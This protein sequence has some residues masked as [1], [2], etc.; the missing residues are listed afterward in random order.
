MPVILIIAGVVIG[1][2]GLASSTAGLTFAGLVVC[3][4]G[5]ASIVA[6]T[7]VKVRFNA[8]VGAAPG[9]DAQ[10]NPAPSAPTGGST[11]TETSSFL[12]PTGVTLRP[13]ES[14]DEMLTQAGLDPAQLV[15]AGPP[16]TPSIAFVEKIVNGVRTSRIVLSGKEV[17][18]RALLA[19][20]LEGTATVNAVTDTEVEVH[21]GHFFVLSLDVSVPD[22]STFNVPRAPVLSPGDKRERVVQG[23]TLPVRVDRDDPTIVVVDWNRV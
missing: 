6:R 20:G 4:A 3:G 12:T 10:L 17:D 19:N 11:T 18:E 23:A 15:P 2:Y 14:I 21:G 13:G 22:R 1:T 7:R 9:P 8:V 16:G 5:L